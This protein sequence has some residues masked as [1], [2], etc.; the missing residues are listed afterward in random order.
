MSDPQSRKMLDL[1]VDGFK[2]DASWIYLSTLGC[3]YPHNYRY[4][5]ME[6]SKSYASQH[7]SASQQVKL[8]LKAYR[9][10]YDKN[11]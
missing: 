6:G 1:V 11:A 10:E 4:L 3:D 5:I 9:I 8:K 2:V 7:Q